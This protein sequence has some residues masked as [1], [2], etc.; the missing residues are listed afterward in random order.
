MHTLR[1]LYKGI[2]L[3]TDHCVTLPRPLPE[4]EL[5]L[6]VRRGEWSEDHVIQHAN[7]LFKTLE[8]SAVASPYLKS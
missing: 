4:R 5:L 2:E 8:E 3:M 1:P 7:R 6:A